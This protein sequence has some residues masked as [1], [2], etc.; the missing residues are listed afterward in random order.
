MAKSL[1]RISSKSLDNFIK[2]LERISENLEKDKKELLIEIAAGAEEVIEGEKD[3][4]ILPSDR[5]IAEFGVGEDGSPDL[6]A[7]NNAWRALLPNPGGTGQVTNIKFLKKKSS[8]G[9]NFTISRK[10]YELDGVTSYLNRSI[11]QTERFLNSLSSSEEIIPII[12]WMEWF[13][14]GAETKE[15]SVEFAD[16]DA[17][18]YDTIT[19]SRTGMAVMAPVSRTNNPFW[20]TPRQEGFWEALKEKLQVGVKKSVIKYI[21]GSKYSTP[22]KKK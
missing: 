17:D 2:R 11:G 16:L 12:P 19:N 7:V 5:A 18:E 9:F 13:I 6:N 3:K 1:A 15:Y 10:F 14:E 22:K 20:S 4:F 21:R 8:F